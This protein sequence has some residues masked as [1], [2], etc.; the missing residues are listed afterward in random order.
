MRTQAGFPCSSLLSVSAWLFPKTFTERALS[1]IHTC[2]RTVE[3][4]V[5][6]VLALLNSKRK[7][8]KA[9]KSSLPC[10]ICSKVPAYVGSSRNNKRC[11]H[12]NT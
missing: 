11:L 7:S 2:S 3:S 9:D 12:E 1:H 8:E 4:A 5:L 10:Q 6:K